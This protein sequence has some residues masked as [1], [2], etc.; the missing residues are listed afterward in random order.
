MNRELYIYWRVRPG[1]EPQ[2][3]AAAATM[4]IQLCSLHPGLCARLLRRSDHANN[5][6]GGNSGNSGV[7]T[8]TLMEIYSDAAVGITPAL[9]SVIATAAQALSGYVEPANGQ[10]GTR[11]VEVFEALNAPRSG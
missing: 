6:N 9:E 1:A 3:Y 10:P 5:G 8:V 7:K 4:Q 2:A 11:H